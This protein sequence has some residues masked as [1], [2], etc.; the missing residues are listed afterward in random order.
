[1]SEFKVVKPFKTVNRRLVEGATIDDGEDISPFTRD[2]REKNGF[3]RKS[4][5]P[6]PVY[7]P[8]DEEPAR[9][10]PQKVR[11]PQSGAE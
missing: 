3:I 11:R 7:Q 10:L 1:M 8:I 6:E 5:A 9:V 4:A 2:E